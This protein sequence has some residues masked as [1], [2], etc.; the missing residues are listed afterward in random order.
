MLPLLIC[1]KRTFSCRRTADSEDVLSRGL[2]LPLRASVAGQ[3]V[4]NFADGRVKQKQDMHQGGGE[5]YFPGMADRV[6]SA[7]V[8]FVFPTANKLGVF[9][10]VNYEN[11]RK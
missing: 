4:L 10:E 11:E 2:G 8:G 1:R 9:T 5:S 7:L 6:T 3:L